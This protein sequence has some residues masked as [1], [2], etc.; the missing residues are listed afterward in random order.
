[1]QYKGTSLQNVDFS[2][3]DISNVVFSSTKILIDLTDDMDLSLYT[4][5]LS[6]SIFAK[7]ELIGKN[8]S[9]ADLTGA[10]LTGADLTGA[11]LTGADL[12]CIGHQI[13]N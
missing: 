13:C 3:L 12:K 8:L 11:D 7:T 6:N 10:E 1:M 5:N 2:N 4:T 9:L